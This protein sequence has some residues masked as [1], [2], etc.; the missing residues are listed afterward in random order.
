MRAGP[1]YLAHTSVG[2]SGIVRTGMRAAIVITK[3]IGSVA[4]L[5][6]SN[7]Q[8]EGPVI[9]VNK[10]TRNLVQELFPKLE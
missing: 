2:R 5:D 8:P 6:K 1:V 9:S 3:A 10:V 7:A 4:L